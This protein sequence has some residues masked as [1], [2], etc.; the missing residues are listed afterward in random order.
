M[1]I[2]H[3]TEV[4]SAYSDKPGT[5]SST[6][7]FL[8]FRES[9]PR[10][11]EEPWRAFL[12]GIDSPSHYDSPEYFLEPHWAGKRPFA[13]LAVHEG[14]VV[15][16]ASGIHV[17]G[18]TVCGV[19]S[20]PQIRIDPAVDPLIAGANL[21]EGLLQE[22]G[23]DKLITV[24]AWNWVPLNGLER[25]GFQRR[26]LEGDVVLDLKMGSDAI[27]K[28]FH[29]NRKRNIRAALK[30][31]IEVSEATTQEDLMAYWDVYS[32]WQQTPRKEIIHNL[33]FDAIEKVHHLRNNNRRFLARFEGKVIAATGLRFQ[34]AGMVEYANNCS[35][36]EFMHLRPNDLLIWR[37]VEWACHQ[38]FTKYSL[39]GAHPFLRKSGGTVIPICRYRLD[40]SFLRQHDLKDSIRAHARSVLAR[41]PA[42]IGNTLRNRMGKK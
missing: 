8:V 4:S 37:T 6:P 14:K 18:S 19:Q 9:P 33:S 39:G 3:R 26:E 2:S 30:N 1:S 41:L 24:F 17:D 42:G 34:P 11:I 40:R 27:Y 23:T 25:R 7:R 12:S 22:A 28:Q 29:E 31:G 10:D 32:R 35:L 36:D 16:L 13:I 38:G 15:G 20:R 21:V 5:R